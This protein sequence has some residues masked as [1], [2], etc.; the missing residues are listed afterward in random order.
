MRA[1]FFFFF[2]RISPN[3]EI[4]ALFLNNVHRYLH[5]NWYIGISSTTSLHMVCADIGQN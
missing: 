5:V 4:K 2:S 1:F 3:A